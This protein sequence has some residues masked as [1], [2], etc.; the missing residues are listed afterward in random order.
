MWQRRY[1]DFKIYSE[2]KLDE[3]LQYMHLNPVRAGLVEKAAARAAVGLC[4]AGFDS[5]L[6]IRTRILLPQAPP[7]FQAVDWPWSSG[8]YCLLGRR[9]GIPLKYIA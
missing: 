8:R 4:I 3:K 9:V 1:Y 6:I 7:A 2:S 5:Q